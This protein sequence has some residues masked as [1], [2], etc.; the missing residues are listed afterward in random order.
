MSDLPVNA[1]GLARGFF[2]PVA[3]MRTWYY[4]LLGGELSRDCSDLADGN[5][6]SSVPGERVPPSN[7]ASRPAPVPRAV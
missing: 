5:P 3:R 2:V 7:R 6:L 4:M 1:G